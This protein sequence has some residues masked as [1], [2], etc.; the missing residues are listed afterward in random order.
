MHLKV[1]TDYAFLFWKKGK[2]NFFRCI[3]LLRLVYTFKIYAN[4]GYFDSQHDYIL[5]K[6]NF[7]PYQVKPN[8]TL[9]EQSCLSARILDLG[10]LKHYFRASQAYHKQ[11]LPCLF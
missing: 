10:F 7:G 9:P 4:D 1:I 11:D 3:L 5:F 8:Q 2:N 6:K